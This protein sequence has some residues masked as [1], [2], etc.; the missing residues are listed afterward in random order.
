MELG[1]TMDRILSAAVPVGILERAAWYADEFAGQFVGCTD[2]DSLELADRANALA[3]A[4]YA[5][6]RGE[7]VNWNDLL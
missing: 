7:T 5:A 6:A 2:E 4:L 1:L 3:R